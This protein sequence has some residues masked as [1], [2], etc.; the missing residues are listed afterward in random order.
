[1]DSY[2]IENLL[3]FILRCPM[4][5]HLDKSMIYQAG[6]KIFGDLQSL[7]LISMSLFGEVWCRKIH[8]DRGRYPWMLLTSGLFSRS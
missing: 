8:I 2:P 3:Y 5:D 4:V 1:M 6:H 7:G